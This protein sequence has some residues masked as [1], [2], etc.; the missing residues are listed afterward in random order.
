MTTR[1]DQSTN[2][3]S[4][5]HEIL[6]LQGGGALGA[7]HAGVFEGLVEAHH[8]A[9]GLDDVHRAVANRHVMTPTRLMPGVN[10]Y[11]LAAKVEGGQANEREAAKLK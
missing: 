10:V 7:Y 11:E 9:A 4:F 1:A 8:W 3:P 6:V 2:R 5:D